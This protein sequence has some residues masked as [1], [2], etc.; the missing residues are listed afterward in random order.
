MDQN[1][2]DFTLSFQI[3]LEPQQL[4]MAGGDQ[5][6][7]EK[8][9]NTADVTQYEDCFNN[10]QELVQPYVDFLL[11][12]DEKIIPN[13]SAGKKKKFIQFVC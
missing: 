2:G 10:P 13:A 7:L 12:S 6:P 3:P 5:D 4:V 9:I 11:G 1:R 8:E